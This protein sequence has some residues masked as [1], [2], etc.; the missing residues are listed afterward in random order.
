MDVFSSFKE[1]MKLANSRSG[2]LGDDL[3]V[4]PFE[5]TSS[6]LATPPGTVTFSRMGVDGVHYCYVSTDIAAYPRGSV[7]QVSP[8]DFGE[9]VTLLAYSFEEYLSRMCATSVSRI[10]EEAAASPASFLAFIKANFND[11]PKFTEA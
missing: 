5:D 7:L 11:R 1:A 4:W 8:M 10:C 3:L 9:P 2:I 6:Y